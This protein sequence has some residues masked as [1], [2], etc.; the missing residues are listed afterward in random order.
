MTPNRSLKRTRL[1]RAAWAGAALKLGW[2]EANDADGVIAPDVKAARPP[3]R[4]QHGR[5]TLEIG[6]DTASL[7][8][9]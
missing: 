7:D 1:R 4:I 3:R 2:V 8:G 6:F 9:T 5:A